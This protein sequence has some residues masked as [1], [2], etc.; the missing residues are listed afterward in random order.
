[1][2]LSALNPY[3][4]DKE[5]IK[6][7][8]DLELTDLGRCGPFFTWHREGC[9]S[10]ID[11]VVASDKF[12]E[13]FPEAIMKNLPW[14]KSNY[15]LVLLTPTSVTTRR[16]QERLFRMNA[17]WFLH[18]DFDT[19]VNNWSFN[20]FGHL[21]R[22]K[23]RILNLLDGIIKNYGS[24]DY[25]SSIEKLQRYLWMELEDILIKEDLMWAQKAKCKWFAMGDRNTKF[26]HAKA[27]G[28]RCRNKIEAIKDE[29]GIWTNDVS[30]I[31]YMATNFFTNLF[32]NEDIDGAYPQIDCTFAPLDK[33]Y[34][35]DL[36]RRVSE[37]EIRGAIFSMGAL[38]SPGPDGLTLSSFNTNG[39]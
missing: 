2:M 9:E 13:S 10:R 11:R 26:F 32:S 18:D 8:D 12:K 15:Q 27:N 17:A 37:E 28:R 3:T 22:Q 25:S 1:M 30:R 20:V 4:I 38:K 16:K 33:S 7:Y 6:W 5:F 39:R 14:F 35:E 19:M 23:N 24:T 29:A 21:G 31:K 36:Q 34:K